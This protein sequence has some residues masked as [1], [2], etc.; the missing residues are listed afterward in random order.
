MRVAYVCADAGVPVYG[1]KG[2]SIHVQE[3]VRS[4]LRRGAQVELYATRVG[5]D[6][7]PGLET[8]LLHEVSMEAGQANGDRE[9]E[10]FRIANRIGDM[11]SHRQEIG[12]K[13]IDLVYERYSL[14]SAKALE[15][16]KSSSIPSILEVN[17]P[18]IDEQREHRSLLNVD[19][20]METSRRAMYAAQ[21]IVAVSSE[22]ADYVERTFPETS[23]RI[24]V[25]PNGVDVDRF[26]PVAERG[27]DGSFVI[28]FVGSLKPWHGIESLLEAFAIVLRALPHA[29]LC[30]VGDGPMRE[31]LE[32]A[33]E[34]MGISEKVEWTGAIL[35]EQVPEMVRRFDVAVAPYM[36]QS[37][38]YFS[39]LKVFEYM[40]CGCA[41]VASD[42]GQLRVLIDDGQNGML[43]EPGNCE[44]MAYQ[45]LKLA[46]H[47]ELRGRIAARARQDAV[48]RHSWARTLESILAIS[49]SHRLDMHRS[50]AVGAGV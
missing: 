36:N 39:P 42:V 32:L 44:A 41:V 46:Y 5:C 35:A 40:A 2:C 18:L 34:T 7:P 16:A 13:K 28:G 43:F 24:H 15:F 21:S 19:L 12:S 33:A 4:F 6:V 37:K 26:S 38:F 22:V 49:E 17:A 9:S 10:R 45:I 23:G 20:A 11:L 29:R 27:A 1:K 31:S 3:I 14:W 30:V 48:E 25:V 50:S 8:C 47:P